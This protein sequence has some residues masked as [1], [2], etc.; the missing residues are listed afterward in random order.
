LDSTLHDVRGDVGVSNGDPL[1]T[2]LSG[3][4]TRIGDADEFVVA[5]QYL[6]DSVQRDALG[7]A[8]PATLGLPRDH[9][10]TVPGNHDHWDG[11]ESYPQPAYNPRLF[12]AQFESCPWDNLAN[13]LLSRNRTLRLEIFGI[14]SSSGLAGTR[15]SLDAGGSIALGEF[16][17]LERALA[18]ADAVPV[19]TSITRARLVICHHSFAKSSLLSPTQVLNRRWRR[20]LTNLCGEFGV[21]AILTGHTHTS[22]CQKRYAGGRAGLDTYE[23]RS[24]TAFQG[25]AEAMKHGFWVHQMYR[26][27]PRA[28]AKWRSRLYLY[29]GGRFRWRSGFDI[30]VEIATV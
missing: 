20:A 16:D 10:F 18:D 13:A 6:H 11:R 25:M 1:Y 14:D 27:A 9:A 17:L 8:K 19:D 2:V 3:D 5:R 26:P 15:K 30:E 4:L 7:R 22:L 24:P 29:S 28:R 23:L 12:P 21:T